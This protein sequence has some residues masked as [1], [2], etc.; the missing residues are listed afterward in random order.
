MDSRIAPARWVADTHQV[1]LQH[2]GLRRSSLLCSRG[3]AAVAGVIPAPREESLW[4]RLAAAALVRWA[5]LPKA[6]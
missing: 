4:P 6:N 2:L 3:A 1:P 5:G